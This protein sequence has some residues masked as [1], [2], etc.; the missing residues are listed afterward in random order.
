MKCIL[1]LL[2]GKQ[3][4]KDRRLGCSFWG[5]FFTLYN[6]I[7]SRGWRNDSIII[8]PVKLRQNEGLLQKSRDIVWDD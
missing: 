3:N 5:W 7:I 1:G 6:R 2:L 4:R 8:L